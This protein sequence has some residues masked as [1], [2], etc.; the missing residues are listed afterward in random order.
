M[1]DVNSTIRFAQ[2]WGDAPS[3]NRMKQGIKTKEVQ[4]LEAENCLKDMA[5][6]FQ[7]G[8]TQS[9]I[10]L[11]AKDII[12]AGYSEE[13]IKEVAKSV[14]F[15]FEKMPTLN[16]LM[17]LLSHKMPKMSVSV[18]EL[19]DLSNRCFFHLKA[20]FMTFGTQEQLTAMCKLYAVKIFPSLA[21]YNAYYQ[22]MAVLNDW[23]RSY[24][25]KGEN[26][27]A[28]GLVTNEAFERNDVEYFVRPLRNYAK[29]N[30]L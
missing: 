6:R 19:T 8:P 4:K 16:Q 10:A 5:L 20:K 21:Q 7:Y 24:F 3:L 12:D 27:L 14:P 1:H 17:E 11:W 30:K 26:I 13:M 2:S 15:K 22:E 9:T 28:Q 18:D 29:E 23:L 25:K